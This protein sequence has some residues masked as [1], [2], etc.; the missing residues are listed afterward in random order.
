MAGAA[1][2]LRNAATD[3]QLTASGGVPL[4]NRIINGATAPTAKY[5]PDWMLGT[6]L[7][8]Q[9]PTSRF[10]TPLSAVDTLPASFVDAGPLY[11]GET[12]RRIH[13]VLPA[14]DIVAMLA[15]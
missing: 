8:R 7:K 2:S 4:A 9:R 1:P 14:A 10:L 12:V 11:A 6:F 5:T 3:A 13:D 15:G